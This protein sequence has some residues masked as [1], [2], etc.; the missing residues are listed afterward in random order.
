VWSL[1]KTIEARDRDAG[2]IF[3]LDMK[4]P[5]L[6]LRREGLLQAHMHVA[7]CFEGRRTRY[8]THDC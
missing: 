6:H 8:I 1:E 5:S 7:S 2:R 4:V 3:A